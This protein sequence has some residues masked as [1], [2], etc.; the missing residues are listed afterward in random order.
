MWTCA[1]NKSSTNACP[2]DAILYLET[3]D[4]SSQPLT[5][6]YPV[7]VREI[8]KLLPPSRHQAVCFRDFNESW[9]DLSC[10][11]RAVPVFENRPT[12]LILR[13]FHL[14][15][16]HSWPVF[17]QNLQWIS[18][19]PSHQH[20]NRYLVRPL[21]WWLGYTMCAQNGRATSFLQ[22]QVPT[23]WPFI[24]RRFNCNPGML[25]LCMS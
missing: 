6:H 25:L 5:C 2:Q 18:Y 4:T 16:K 14:S 11:F 19:L 3:G 13:T 12:V 23:L 9:V 15:T 8:S 22:P 17:D 7:K 21:H 10:L 20:Q 24:L 1:L